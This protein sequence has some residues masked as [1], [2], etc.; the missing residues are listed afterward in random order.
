LEAVAAEDV[1]EAGCDHHP[2]ACILQRPSCVLTRRTAAEVGPGEQNG[3]TPVLRPVQ[4]EAGLV[5]LPVVEEEGPEPGALD[6]LQELLGDDL[7]GVN[8]G[9]VQRCHSSFVAAE[10]SHQYAYPRSRPSASG[11]SP[12]GLLG[13]VGRG[14][15][16][17]SLTSARW[18]GTAAAPALGGGSRWRRPPPPGRPSKLRSD[19]ETQRSPGCRMSGFMPRHIEPP[20]SRHSKPAW[21]NTRSR[22]SASASSLTRAEPGTTIAR[23]RGC[24]CRPCATSA[25]ARRSSRRELVQE[26]M[27]TRSI[28]MSWIA[29]PG[30]RAM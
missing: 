28:G 10:G 14:E 17:I 30:C 3:S 20:A 4:H 19:V 29:V 24:T 16:A 1:R 15:G 6:A 7:V 27:N 23:T 9:P 13:R 12:R 21:V 22:P 8:V 25:A 5:S 18:A 26:P 2:E 11:R